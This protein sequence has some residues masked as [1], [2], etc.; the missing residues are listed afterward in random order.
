MNVYTYYEDI[1]F[2][3]QDQLIDLWRSSWEQAGFNPVV[4][5][6]HHVKK[7]PYYSEFKHKLNEIHL[8][9]TG[10]D[11]DNYCLSC[12]LRWMAYST[13]DED[14]MIVCDYDVINSGVSACEFKEFNNERINLITGVCPALAI[15]TP[16]QFSDLCHTFVDMAL[17][18]IDLAREVATTTDKRMG[19]VY[20]D[21]H[22][23]K[24]FR[25]QLERSVNI[26]QTNIM[27]W[28]Y[29]Q[30]DKKLTH[31]SHRYVYEYRNHHPEEFSNCTIATGGIDLIRIDLI[32]DKL[33]HIINKK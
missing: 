26:T 28:S 19:E 23:F 18:N 16:Q 5:N 31:F 30:S 12:F 20:H 7:N 33:K 4:L 24:L 13:I 2:N 22:F 14:S 21:Q 9:I 15:G 27:A 17:S 11:I 8:A 25:E 3:K 1:G 32:R 10:K 29:K 6:L